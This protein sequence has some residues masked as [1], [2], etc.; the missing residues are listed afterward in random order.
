[1]T[2]AE[3]LEIGGQR[4]TP[5]TCSSPPISF[6]DIRLSFIDNNR[7]FYKEMPGKGFTTFSGDFR[8]KHMNAF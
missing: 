7:T 3:S 5:L 8:K 6:L 1:M 4:R 2:S